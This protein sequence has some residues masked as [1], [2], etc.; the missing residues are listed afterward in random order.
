MSR[1]FAFYNTEMDGKICSML[2]DGDAVMDENDAEIVL[3]NLWDAY[4]D[5][6]ERTAELEKENRGLKVHIKNGMAIQEAHERISTEDSEY[7]GSY[8][9][10]LV[11]RFLTE[12]PEFSLAAHNLEQK[13]KGIESV[14]QTGDYVSNKWLRE[15]V[16][17]LRNQ[18]KALK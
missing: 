5:E 13:I 3:N 9:Y 11:E 18:A 4:K 10:G 8:V 17:N 14:I 16:E 15:E 6:V 1:R 12:S 7:E 2:H